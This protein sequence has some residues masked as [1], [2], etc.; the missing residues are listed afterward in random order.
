FGLKVALE[1]SAAG[2][3]SEEGELVADLDP[4][5]ALTPLQLVHRGLLQQATVVAATT[6][7]SHEEPLRAAQR[8][9][10][11]L[12]QH[13]IIAEAERVPGRRRPVISPPVKSPSRCSGWRSSRARFC[14]C[15]PRSTASPAKRAWWWSLPTRSE[16][17]KVSPRRTRKDAK[18]TNKTRLF[19]R[20]LRV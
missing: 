9:A 10:R 5:P 17:M 20:V 3:E 1:L 13:G 15:A 8:A 6:G 16:R 7:G 18:E 19:L 12:R 2:F 11:K 4:A 14:R